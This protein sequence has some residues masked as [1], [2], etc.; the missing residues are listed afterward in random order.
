M[1]QI[2]LFDFDTPWVAIIQLTLMFILPTLVGLVTDRLSASWIKVA[3]LGGLTFASTILTTLLDTMLAGTEYD[4]VNMIANGL[5]T[6]A[7]AIAAYLGILKPTGMAEAAQ[8]SNV[9]QIFGPSQSRID[10]DFNFEE[11]AA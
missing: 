7:L 8:S 10:Q 6:W 1:S 2:P 11:K 4:W 3:L 9:I 5:I